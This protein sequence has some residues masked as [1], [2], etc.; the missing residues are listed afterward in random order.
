M[1]KT[2]A[3][4]VLAAL[5]AGA[6]AANA[7]ESGAEPAPY[8]VM[9]AP[10][11]WPLSGSPWRIE[12]GNQFYELT[13]RGDDAFLTFEGDA[14]IDLFFKPEY[15]T[16]EPFGGYYFARGALLGELG[17]SSGTLAVRQHG[18]VPSYESS[19][20]YGT[21][22][23]VQDADT[24]WRDG[25]LAFRIDAQGGTLTVMGFS[26]IGHGS[27]ED[28]GSDISV[29]HAATAAV[30]NLGGWRWSGRYRDL[31]RPYDQ[32]Y[33]AQPLDVLAAD[34]MAFGAS[35]EE[36]EKR[37]VNLLFGPTGQ[38]V[39]GG[40][41]FAPYDGEEP[42]AALRLEEGAR[43]AFE[44][45]SV[46]FVSD[47]AGANCVYFSG[48]LE[49]SALPLAGFLADESLS[50]P[51][52]VSGLENATVVIYED[53]LVHL[54]KPEHR[55]SGWY[56]VKHAF[57]SEGPLKE[58]VDALMA[59][60]GSGEAGKTLLNMYLTE[61]TP[62]LFYSSVEQLTQAAAALG[63]A[64]AMDDLMQESR[65]EFARIVRAGEEGLPVRADIFTSRRQG[66]YEMSAV[67]EPRREKHRWKRDA[68]GAAVA[69]DGRLGDW[70]LGG[71]LVY[72]DADVTL[73]DVRS[74]NL[75]IDS[76]RAD[77]NVLSALAYAGRRFAWGAAGLS[78]G[79]AGGED[80]WEKFAQFMHGA[81]LMIERMR[82]RAYSAGL[83]AVWMPQAA[84]DWKLSLEAGLTH[85]L[86]T[87][88]DYGFEG[89]EGR[90]WS[91]REPA[92]NVSALRLSAGA[93]RRWS[94]ARG[95]GEPDDF[96]ELSADAYSR[97]RAGDLDTEQEVCASGRCAS[98]Q[99]AG[100]A[101]AQAG[102]AL[103]AQA[104]FRG[105]RFG[106][107]TAAEAGSGGKRAVSADIRL[108]FDF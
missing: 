24:F 36:A 9:Q 35:A 4:A 53:G 66:R 43:V 29:G 64:Q 65:D 61:P 86:F 21:A 70:L 71:W 62:D 51:G 18:A 99:V 81:P 47:R 27:P 87:D 3:A 108:I 20:H 106:L 95:S 82:R 85:T 10:E 57:E 14:Q 105:S 102:L 38:L 91:V 5:A 98:M 69:V 84:G 107:R 97:L 72:E 74:L 28:P 56:L 76:D 96:I 32:L 44:P 8:E 16:E 13:A 37:G 67:I 77:S 52:A 90:L 55:S 54:M 45:G 103:G 48:R 6:P 39:L 50:G 34:R 25:S 75:R 59:R 42:T 26:R 1:R 89:A 40:Q 11:G 15:E 88:A 93:S 30:A 46:I 22:L 60:L 92:R 80:R 19:W 79:F 101:R 33:L 100:L 58:P 23:L 104:R 49:T 63:T 31:D 12:A 7:G 2:L 78:L 17:G 41:W 73:R 68:D 83:S 94:F